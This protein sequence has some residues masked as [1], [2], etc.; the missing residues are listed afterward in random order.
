MI[1]FYGVIVMSCAL[2]MITL[3]VI[4]GK[5]TVLD[6]NSIKWFRFTF[7]LVAMGMTFEYVGVLFSELG[8]VPAWLVVVVTLCEYSLS[9]CLTLALA[10]SCGIKASIKPMFAVMAF[11]AVLEVAMAPFKLIFFITEED[12]CLVMIK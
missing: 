10:K 7:I 3:A 4:V 5:N 9:P 1:S 2:S 11:H 8:N 12:K 6:K